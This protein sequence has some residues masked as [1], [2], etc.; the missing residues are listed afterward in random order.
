MGDKTQSGVGGTISV[1]DN[2][3]EGNGLTDRNISLAKEEF[4]QREKNEVIE[5]RC[6][7]NIDEYCIQS[8]EQHIL[9]I[10]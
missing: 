7:E 5:E 3:F 10:S 1:R 6:D 2:I 4:Y 9:E 8:M